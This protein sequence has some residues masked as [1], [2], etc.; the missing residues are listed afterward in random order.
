[1]HFLYI[2]PSAL[3]PPIPPLPIVKLLARGLI[4]IIPIV[5]FYKDARLQPNYLVLKTILP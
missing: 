5:P 2:P 4:I 1:M 3:P